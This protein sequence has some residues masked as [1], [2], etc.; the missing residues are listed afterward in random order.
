MCWFGSNLV[1]FESRHNVSILIPLIGS[2]CQGYLL[3][4]EGGK[5]RRLA[6]WEEAKFGN[7]VWEWVRSALILDWIR[8]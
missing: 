5:G 6:G 7:H 2:A 3:S 1:K 4:A 8:A